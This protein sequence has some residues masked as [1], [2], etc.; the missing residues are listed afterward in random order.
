MFEGDLSKKIALN[1]HQ[2]NKAAKAF[3]M[4]QGFVVESESDEL[5]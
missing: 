2:N 4:S 1:V 3:Y 5:V